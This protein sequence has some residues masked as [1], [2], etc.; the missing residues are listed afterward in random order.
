[1]LFFYFDGLTMIDNGKNDIRAV[2]TVVLLCLL[3]L[4]IVGMDWV[5]R[6]SQQLPVGLHISRHG[7]VIRV[8]QQPEA[9]QQLGCT[10]V[11]SQH[12]TKVSKWIWLQWLVNILQRSTPGVQKSPHNSR[13]VDWVTR[14]S[15]QPATHKHRNLDNR[16]HSVSV[17]YMI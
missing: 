1:M 16:F 3:G 13:Q 2:G 10:I 4:T 7:W 15:Q 14:V 6:V 17:Q 9:H 11:T 5:T 8:S 12:L